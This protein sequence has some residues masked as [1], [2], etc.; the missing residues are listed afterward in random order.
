M[1]K[2]LASIILTA[3]L[4]GCSDKN[5]NSVSSEKEVVE[6][7][8]SAELTSVIEE[9][10]APTTESTT[11]AEQ[12]FDFQILEVEDDG[13]T[14]LV[15][16][17]TIQKIEIDCTEI[18]RMAEIYNKDPAE[19][20]VIKDYNFDGYDDLFVPATTLVA[21]LPG[22]YYRFNPTVNFSPFE[23]WDELNE[24]GFLMKADSEKGIL[25][26][27]SKGSAVDHDWIIYKWK[28]G[29]LQPVSRELQ[30][31]HG[32]EIYIDCFEYDNDGNET[33]VKRKRAVL[34][35]NNEWLGTEEIE[36]LSNYTFSINESGVDVLLDGKVIQTLECDYSPD[37][38]LFFEDY[39]FD[40]YKDLFVMMDNGA[41][42]SNGTYFRYVPDT[43]LFEKWD[44]L[45][46]I[47]RAM[48]VNA[49]N[50][51]LREKR[52]NN[53]YWLEYFDYKWENNRLDLFEHRLSKNGEVMEIYS[54]APDGSEKLIGSEVK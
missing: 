53:D 21:N 14:V 40:G 28:S 47:G 9:T 43:G 7:T 35:E 38:S 5:E 33:L 22:T 19:L 25:N 45:N 49:E 1:K 52:F 3:L 50:S 20:L 34:G 10:T 26:F 13:I 16:N 37:D 30:Y 23:E 29:K 6:S 46:K 36:I 54:V 39:D 4:T 48:I 11:E 15:A 24:I 41:M 2:F 8:N 27:S 42:Y 18:L 32:S 44:E 17:N 51:T 31:M 12:D